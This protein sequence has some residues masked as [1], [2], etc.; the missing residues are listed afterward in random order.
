[1]VPRANGLHDFESPSRGRCQMQNIRRTR[2]PS[3]RTMNRLIAWAIAVLV[4]GAF[5]IGIIYVL[6]RYAATPPSIV[7]QKTTALEEALRKAP[8]NLTMR[9]QLAGAYTAGQKY[10]EAVVQFDQ[11][12]TAAATLENGTGFIKSAHLGRG[13]ALRLKGDLATAR[14]D[15]QAIVDV[16]KDGEFAGQ[17]VELQAA[18][19]ALGTIALAEDKPADAIDVLNAS[20]RINKTDADT[21]HLLGAAYLKNGAA[22]KAVD[23]IRKAILFVPIGWCEPYTALGQAYTTLGQADEAAWAGAMSDY[24]LKTPGDVR[25]RLEALVVGP[26]AVDAMVG[27]G[28]VAELDGDRAA[29]AGWYGKAVARDPKN[30][31]ATSGLARVAED[32]NGPA[33]SA[34]AV[35]ASAAPGGAS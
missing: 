34:P 15:Y 24:C 5:T 32:P 14:A 28:T 21:L 20:L 23:P 6:D 8:N 16:A 7:N 31:S 13:D 3:D 11:V 4:V 27:L 17:D 35:P 1:M 19:F 10:D 9:L 25:P 29:A 26:A 33:P 2:G 18:Y 12:L 30:F 22:D